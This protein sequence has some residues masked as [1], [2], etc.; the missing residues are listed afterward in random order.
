[1][2]KKG[3]SSAPLIL[4]IIGS[5]LNIPAALCGAACGAMVSSIGKAS[6]SGAGEFFGNSIIAISVIA[7]LSGLI[8]GILSKPNPTAGGLLMIL[9]TLLT[10][11]E[12]FGGGGL[13][14]LMVFLL[15]LIGA[16]ICFT[17][18]KIDA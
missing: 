9:A 13:F 11:L 7:G 12:I 10:G 1:M 8:G 2:K 18:E 5:V 14:A 16:I 4:G 15:Y 3:T 6:H 17:Q